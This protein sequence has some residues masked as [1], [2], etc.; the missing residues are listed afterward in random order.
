M[1]ITS[2]LP[3]A[4]LQVYSMCNNARGNK[5]T[6]HGNS[7]FSVHKHATLFNQIDIVHMACSTDVDSHVIAY[8]FKT[9]PSTFVQLY[10]PVAA[11]I[12]SREYHYP[13]LVVRS[14]KQ[15]TQR[16]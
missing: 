13:P 4:L 9:S 16:T 6:L 3:S 10:R 5:R 14:V 2:L 12:L 15:C 11:Q 7:D 8:N 1:A